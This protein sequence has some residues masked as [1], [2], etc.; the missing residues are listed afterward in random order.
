M[1]RIT[2]IAIFTFGFLVAGNA[3]AQQKVLANVPFEFT[4]GA[5][6][7]PP[8]HYSITAPS[9][10][11]IEIRNLDRQFAVVA[12]V[13]NADQAL[14]RRNVLVFEERAGHYSLRKILCQSDLMNFSLLVRP[15][16][17]NSLMEEAKNTGTSRTVY[18]ATGE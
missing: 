13:R 1:K 2:A 8:G 3:L 14:D 7:L 9:Q 16:K 18:V 4:V 6:T 12:L 15:W 17:K 5:K 11:G 10:Y